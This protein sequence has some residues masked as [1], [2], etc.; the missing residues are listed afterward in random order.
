MNG[1]VNSLALMALFKSLR[2]SSVS[3]SDIYK[4]IDRFFEEL[5]TKPLPY[6]VPTWK[7]FIQRKDELIQWVTTNSPDSDVS[8]WK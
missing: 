8:E 1:E 5:K 4:M 2:T 3:Y 6:E 7:A